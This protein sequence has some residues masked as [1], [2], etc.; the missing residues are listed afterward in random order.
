MMFEKTMPV[1]KSTLS[2]LTYFSAIWRPTSGLNWSSPMSTSAG[3]PPSLPPFSLTA[4]WKPS[5]IST[6]SA[7]LGP[8]RVLMKPTLTLS[9]ACELGTCV[10]ARAHA[11]A[12]NVLFIS[13]LLFRSILPLATDPANLLLVG[14]RGPGPHHFGEARLF[15]GRGLGYRVERVLQHRVVVGAHRTHVGAAPATG[16]HAR[17]AQNAL[18]QVEAVLGAQHRFLLLGVGLVDDLAEVVRKIGEAV[19]RAVAIARVPIA[20]PV[21]DHIARA[22]FQAAAAFRAMA[23][24]F[25]HRLVALDVDRGKHRGQQ[26]PGAEFFCKELQIQTERAEAR[27]DRGVRQGHQRSHV[28]CR[29]AVV[30]PGI[31]MGGRHNDRRVAR[32]LQPVHELERRFLERGERQLVVVVLV[33]VVPRQ[34]ARAPGLHAHREHDSAAAIVLGDLACAHRFAVGDADQVGAEFERLVLYFL[35]SERP[36]E[37]VH[38]FSFSF[39]SR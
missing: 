24:R 10:S 34:D 2:S 21:L 36:L 16:D 29:V 22:R 26:D 13:Y 4:S 23:Q 20:L 39:W 27:L 15:G 14:G 8:E 19:R 32:V 5:R 7:P 9:A 33:A 38:P 30:A 6:P 3:R 37:D 35:C 1:R 12:K 28:L 11:I 18:P 25:A 31:D 17:A